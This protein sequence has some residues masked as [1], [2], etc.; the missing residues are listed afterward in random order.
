MLLSDAEYQRW[1]TGLAI[2]ERYDT[3]E[4]VESE[5]DWT[6]KQKEMATSFLK[7]VKAGKTLSPKQLKIIHDWH[8]RQN[9]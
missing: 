2:Y 8:G 3:L 1:W 6:E 9:Y 4:R 7:Q 5:S